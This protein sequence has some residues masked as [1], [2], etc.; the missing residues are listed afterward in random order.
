METEEMTGDPP[1]RA[2][3]PEEITGNPHDNAVSSSTATTSSPSEMDTTDMRRN[4]MEGRC[5][6]QPEFKRA[7]VGGDVEM[8]AVDE[9]YGP[10]G[11]E[12]F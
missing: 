12:V 11:C 2:G 7:R 4:P 1:D 5:D 3:S 8:C 10:V 6:V 9:E